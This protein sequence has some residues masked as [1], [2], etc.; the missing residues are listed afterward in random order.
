[1]EPPTY[2]ISKFFNMCPIYI[3]L[4]NFVK[5]YDQ[6]NTNKSA[7]ILRLYFLF[8]IS[9]FFFLRGH[10]IRGNV[11]QKWYL[12]RSSARFFVKNKQRLYLSII[13]KYILFYYLFICP[14]N[15]FFSLKIHA[16]FL[17]PCLFLFLFFF[18]FIYERTQQIRIYV[19]R[20]Y[21]R[22]YHVEFDKSIVKYV[23]SFSTFEES[24]DQN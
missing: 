3:Y 20:T 1:M 2:L 7:I 23:F 13:K 10:I 9:F 8:V 5:N 22:V 16:T 4:D 21:T 18:E 11:R 17:F 12:I 24:K 14:F 19:V 15:F 6:M